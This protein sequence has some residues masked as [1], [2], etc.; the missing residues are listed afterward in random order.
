MP[1]P[2][3]R[4]IAE[5]GRPETA[6][7]LLTI[8]EAAALLRVSCPRAYELARS[9]VLPAVRLGR[10]IRIDPVQLR[11]WIAQGGRALPGGWRHDPG[12]A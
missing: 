7:A 2:G 12:G 6:P 3:A 4:V 10:Q 5:R 9:G 1:D 11:T 8:Q